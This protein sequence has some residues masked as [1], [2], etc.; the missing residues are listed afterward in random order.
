MNLLSIFCSSSAWRSEY[1]LTAETARF[2]C[3]LLSVNPGYSL[4]KQYSANKQSLVS[5]EPNQQEKVLS[6]LM[7][8]PSNM[9]R[10]DNA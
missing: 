7:A 4:S 8:V 1:H 5:A 3:Q 10:Y 6:S 9:R 2:H